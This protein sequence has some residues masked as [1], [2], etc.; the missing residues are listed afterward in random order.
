[1]PFYLYQKEP[2][3]EAF[4]QLK[5]ISLA[6]HNAIQR[7]WEQKGKPLDEGWNI[8]QDELI[9]HALNDPNGS[10]RSHRMIIDLVPSRKDSIILIEVLH[11]YLY[12]YDAGEGTGR[13]GW[14][15]LMLKLRDIFAKECDHELPEGEKEETLRRFKPTR[16]ADPRFSG[17]N[18]TFLY[19]QGEDR[20]WPWGPVGMVN[21]AIIHR[22]ARKYFSEVFCRFSDTE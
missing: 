5:A 10:S 11:I 4:R 19:L 8:S 20:G 9:R 13:A 17:Q 21:G 3:E 14:T 16:P 7:L 22:P 15:V 2:E 1:M 6:G 18:Y 12:T